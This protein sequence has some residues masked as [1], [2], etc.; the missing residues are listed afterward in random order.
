MC[1]KCF[2]TPLRRLFPNLQLPERLPN[3]TRRPAWVR[4]LENPPG[5]LLNGKSCVS[6][7]NQAVVISY[8]K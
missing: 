4:E 1:I 3:P 8:L 6:S 2:L 5:C 7:V